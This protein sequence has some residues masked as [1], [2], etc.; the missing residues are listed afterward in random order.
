MIERDVLLSIDLPQDRL[1][2]ERVTVKPRPGASGADEQSA[3][4]KEILGCRDVVR[5]ATE[6]KQVG[7]RGQE[8]R[9]LPILR[10][11]VKD[12]IRPGYFKVAQARVP[13]DILVRFL[14]GLVEIPLHVI[15][16]G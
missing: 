5:G 7:T 9:M 2:S 14:V 11:L 6:R 1:A 15:R 8:G 3:I 16:Q 13:A 10:K 12:G 4:G